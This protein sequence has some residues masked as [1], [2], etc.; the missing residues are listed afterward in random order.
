MATIRGYSHSSPVL[1]AS[2]PLS[3][4]LK[5]TLPL[6]KALRQNRSFANLARLLGIANGDG[7]GDQ[8]PEADGDDVDN[9]EIEEDV[10]DAI[11]EESLMW[12]A[13]VSRS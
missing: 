11:D 4:S 8:S 1:D 3:A 5:S 9:G 2:S 6:P 12:D 7:E 13:Q 10:A